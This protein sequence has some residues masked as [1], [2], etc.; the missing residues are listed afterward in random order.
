[1]SEIGL[2]RYVL[3]C[4]VLTVPIL[5]WNVVFTRFLPPALASTEF[6]QDIPPLVASGENALRIV[7]MVLPFLMPLEVETD[8]QRQGL[9]LFVL[10]TLLYFLAWGAVDDRAPI[11]MEYELARIRCARIHP[12]RMARGTWSDRPTPLRALAVQV[13]DVRGAGL[14]LRR[15]SCHAH[16]HRVCTETAIVRGPSC[17]DFSPQV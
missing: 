8:D 6:S 2:A 11:S 4:G 10:G 15:F 5:M 1:M 7:V 14:W 17:F 16:Q 3:S 12:A 13:V 9:L